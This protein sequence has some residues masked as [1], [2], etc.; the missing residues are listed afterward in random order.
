VAGSR[1][2]LSTTGG[3]IDRWV[4]ARDVEAPVVLVS[5]IALDRVIFTASMFHGLLFRRD[6]AFR[7]TFTV[8]VSTRRAADR[9]RGQERVVPGGLGGSETAIAAVDA[10][11]G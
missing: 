6:A 11:R 9:V 3:P 10:A 4:A 5:R 2:G 1:P 8:L 7:D